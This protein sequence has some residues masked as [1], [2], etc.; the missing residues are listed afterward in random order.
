MAAS[1]W[2]TAYRHPTS[3]D[4]RCARALACFV[5]MYPSV[6]GGAHTSF[7][8][9]RQGVGPISAISEGGHEF[10]EISLVYQAIQ[11]DWVDPPATVQDDWA[12]P[13]S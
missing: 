7:A 8:D 3:P 5:P 13:A 4:H 9:G 10:D 11:L 2:A 1:S 12:A 6:I